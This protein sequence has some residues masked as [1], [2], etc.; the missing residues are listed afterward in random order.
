MFLYSGVLVVSEKLFL[1]RKG[2][3]IHAQDAECWR[4]H[5]CAAARTEHLVKGQSCR[6]RGP[7]RSEVLG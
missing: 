3:R 5:C 4:K 6:R 1:R 2:D 7:E